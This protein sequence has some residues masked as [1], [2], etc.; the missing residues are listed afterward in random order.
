MRLFATLRHIKRLAEVEERLEGLERQMKALDMEWSDVYDELRG[1]L[2]KISKRKKFI[3][4][5]EA[6]AG[7][8]G[9][10]PQPE[11]PLPDIHIGGGL[12]ERQRGF[13]QEILKRRARL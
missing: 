10:S 7:S 9:A 2:G 12:D 13:Q 3:E 1:M 11:L 4:K 6:E 5:H 8:N